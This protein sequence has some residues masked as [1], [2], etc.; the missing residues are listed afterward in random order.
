[1]L[2]AKDLSLPSSA[3]QPLTTSVPVPGANGDDLVVVVGPDLSSS[4]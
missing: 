2:L 1:M 4:S 3:V